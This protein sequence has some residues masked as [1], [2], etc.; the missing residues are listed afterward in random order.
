MPQP[1]ASDKAADAQK[2]M[3]RSMNYILP[4]MTV[5]IVW[6]LP[7]GLAFYWLVSTLL[8]LVQDYYLYKKH[9]RN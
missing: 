3:A 6:N 2:S 9:G 7:A 5:F 8:G 1:G 4:V